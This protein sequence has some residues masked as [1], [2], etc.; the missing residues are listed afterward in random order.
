MAVLLEP[1]YRCGC[2]DS[3]AGLETRVFSDL[4]RR[5]R[6][7]VRE[8]SEYTDGTLGWFEAFHF[9]IL[10]IMISSRLSCRIKRYVFRSAA[11]ETTSVEMIVALKT[12]L[13][14]CCSTATMRSTSLVVP[15]AVTCTCPV[16]AGDSASTYD[17]KGFLNWR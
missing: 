9:D 12:R 8:R 2:V 17:S 1:T 16:S 15:L 4:A 3:W 14:W 11:I 13:L 7:I 6:S 5:E 10:R